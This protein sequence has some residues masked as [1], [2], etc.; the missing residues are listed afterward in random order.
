[1]ASSDIYESKELSGAKTE[2]ELLASQRRRR[3][4]RSP[5]SF[6]EV[7]NKDVS[8]T[9]RRRRRNTGLRRFQHLMKKPEFNRK[10][11][12]ITLSACALILILLLVW[13]RFFRYSTEKPGYSP[14][15]Y[16]AVIK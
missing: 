7:I 10:F 14:D 2:D 11:W 3:S 5:Q 1:M 9:H 16:R 6:D 13:D 8:E 12:T 15:T 4:R